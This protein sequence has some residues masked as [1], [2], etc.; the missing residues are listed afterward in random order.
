MRHNY[1]IFF[2]CLPFL[3]LTACD[4]HRHLHDLE[5]FVLQTKQS[6]VQQPK[7]NLLANMVEPKAVY[8]SASNIR[9]PFEITQS[10]EVMGKINT[11]HPLE[12]YPTEILRYKGMAID[13]GVTIGYILTPDNKLYEVKIGDI[14]G[15]HNGKIINIY[16]DRIE[17]EEHVETVNA[18]GVPTISQRVVTLQ[19]KEEADETDA[20]KK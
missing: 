20:T 6:V 12:S 17:A 5:D 2:Y 4:S 8:Y 15:T 19:P 1:K 9:S 14:I 3:M 10:E 11:A 13:Q 16:P 7:K 18:K